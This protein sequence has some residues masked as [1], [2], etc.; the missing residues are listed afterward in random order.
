MEKDFFNDLKKE[1]YEIQDRHPQLSPD[2]AFVAWFMRAFTT[3]DEKS[4]VHSI[5]GKAGDKSAD[6]ICCPGEVSPKK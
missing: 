4:V 5:T 3:E 1:V 2:N 6:A